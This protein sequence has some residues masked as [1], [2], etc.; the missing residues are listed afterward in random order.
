MTEQAA[1]Q[2]RWHAACPN[3][4]APLEFASAA[5]ASAVCSFCRSTLLREGDALRKI[6]IS[7][8]LLEDYSPLQL[9]ARGRYAGEAFTVLGRLQLANGDALDSSNP[10]ATWN[11]WHAV[12]DAGRSAWLAED[13]GQFVI[14]F[15]TPLTEPAP[16][17]EQLVLGDRVL[18]AGQSWQVSALSQSRVLAAQGELPHAPVL[19]AP[20]CLAELRNAQNEVGSLDYSAGPNPQWSL[21]R[22]VRMADLDL[23]GLRESKD[24]T[25]A[26]RGLSCPN[27]GAALAPKLN[28]SR[29]I[30]CAQ[31]RAVVDLSPTDGEALHHFAQATYASAG[32]EPQIPLGRS[33]VLA[34]QPDQPRLPWQV[35]GYQERCDLPE[36]GSDDEQ[37]FWRE[38]LLFNQR[39]GFAFLVDTE[40][41]WS[42]V[43]T[44]TGTPQGSGATLQWQGQ[45]FKQRWHYAAK[46]THVLG[47]FYWQ[48][49]QDQVAQV[50]DYESASGKAGAVL[51]R[52]Q[53]A[54]E[55]TWSL[56]RRLPASEVAQ[57]FR[58]EPEQRAALTRDTPLLSLNG[59]DPHVL[60]NVVLC[61]FF[62]ALLFLLLKSCSED[63]CQRY[64]DSF[65]E[66]S[67]EYTQCKRSGG[68]RIH[69]GGSGGAYGGSYGGAGSSGGGHK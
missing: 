17:A 10:A 31:C 56:G 58:L 41:G 14:S 45:R 55:I 57:A 44:L 53:T 11:E 19:N 22:P 69:S 35:V 21:G 7:A 64:K 50:T 15:E 26:A 52:E 30:V 6:G 28:N 8:E 27:C 3:C 37:S 24:A 63:D 29:S 36:P 9:G 12:F 48:V 54:H 38:Y 46:V 13:N 49:Q 33:G 39:E 62:L 5:S 61:L 23:Q 47:E 51:S 25:L 60:R 2:R 40:E 18:L 65:G 43:R 34:L 42:L 32:H 16:R 1:P 66:S 67:A 68:G 59:S 4:G 20:F